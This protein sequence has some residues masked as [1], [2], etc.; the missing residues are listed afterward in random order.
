[1]DALDGNVDFTYQDG[2]I[3]VW[4]ADRSPAKKREAALALSNLP[5]V[6]ATYTR[7]GDGYRLRWNNGTTNRSERRWWRNHAQE[8]IDTMAAPNGPDAVAL[9]R[10]NVSYGVEGDHGGHQ[11][12][13][14]RIPMVF[15]WPG[16][17]AGAQPRVRIRSVDILPTI[18]ELMGIE[19]DPAH[20]TDGRAR[21]LPLAP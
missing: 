11:R 6:I 20:P 5:A 7:A 17:E 10:D 12:P 1:V 2:H 13:I 4:L 18:L 9:L 15:S 3:G 14:Q 21:P 16:L 19:E 8:L